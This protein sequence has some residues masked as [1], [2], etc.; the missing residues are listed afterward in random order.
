LRKDKHDDNAA[1]HPYPK[2]KVKITYL[3]CFVKVAIV[4]ILPVLEVCWDADGL[5]IN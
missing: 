1:D 2:R 5:I 4:L 3:H